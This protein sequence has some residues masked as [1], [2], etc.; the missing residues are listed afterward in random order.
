[1]NTYLEASIAGVFLGILSTMIGYF[2]QRN[3]TNFEWT[4][5]LLRI[6]CGICAVIVL[7]YYEITGVEAIA[8]GLALTEF[9]DSGF[10]LL[11]RRVLGKQL[12]LTKEE[13]PVETYHDL[14]ICT[15]EIEPGYDIKKGLIAVKTILE[16]HLNQL[17]P[18]DKG[19]LAMVS[20]VTTLLSAQNKAG[21][22]LSE[23]A[24]KRVNALIRIWFQYI[25]A[26]E[27]DKKSGFYE[28][29]VVYYT[30]LRTICE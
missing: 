18:Q 5:L 23:E 28:L 4:P 22:E 20:N 24:Y 11:A 27:E 25:I 21:K 10:K 13:I 3:V 15:G 16:R 26:T 9:N 2:K 6:P 1:M 7:K 29:A 12:D 19:V 17:K 8:I 14:I 30:D